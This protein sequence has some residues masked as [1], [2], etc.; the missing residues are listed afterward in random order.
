MEDEKKMEKEKKY[1]CA[2]E[3]EWAHSIPIAFVDAAE[4]DI[5]ARLNP[6]STFVACPHAFIM[7]MLG[8]P[9]S[10]MHPN[11]KGLPRYSMFRFPHIWSEF[12]RVCMWVSTSTL[13]V[14]HCEIPLKALPT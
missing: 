6:Q 2:E 1:K 12:D 13:T 4:E 3:R 10:A 14:F 7:S 5:S 9:T 11:K 8:P